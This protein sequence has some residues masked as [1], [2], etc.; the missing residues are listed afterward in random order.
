MIKIKVFCEIIFVPLRNSYFSLTAAAM[1]A[2]SCS[3]SPLGLPPGASMP[4]LTWHQSPNSVGLSATGM[5]TFGSS[6]PSSA[7]HPNAQLDLSSEA[8]DDSDSSR[9]SNGDYGNGDALPV[10]ID[11]SDNDK[12]ASIKQE[13]WLWIHCT[14]RKESGTKFLDWYRHTWCLFH[15]SF[16]Y[17]KVSSVFF[18]EKI[19]CVFQRRWMVTLNILR[20]GYLRMRAFLFTVTV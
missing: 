19:D 10:E 17:L 4:P 7:F 18:V 5:P 8:M 13:V 2:A 3:M 11:S 16:F 9:D 14:M 1:A 12:A 20:D 15:F 6:H